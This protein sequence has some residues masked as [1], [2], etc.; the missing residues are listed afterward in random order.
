MKN[1]KIFYLLLFFVLN[2]SNHLIGQVNFKH[3]LFSVL[4]KTLRPVYLNEDSIFI[5]MDGLGG[6]FIIPNAFSSDTLISYLD[7]K[8]SI[9]NILTLRDRD[10]NYYN[11]TYETNV[12]FC[13]DFGINDYVILEIL[14]KKRELKFLIPTHLI[15][16]EVRQSS[17][18]LIEFGKYRLFNFNNQTW[19]LDTKNNLFSIVSYFIKSGK[20]I[21][22]RIRAIT[23]YGLTDI[24]S[25]LNIVKKYPSSHYILN[26]IEESTNLLVDFYQDTISLINLETLDTIRKLSVKGLTSSKAFVDDSLIF[27]FHS[28]YRPIEYYDVL[29][30]YDLN[31]SLIRKDTFDLG[32][33]NQTTEILLKK[34]HFIINAYNY[35][36]PSIFIVPTDKINLIQLPKLK[37]VSLTG[38]IDTLKPYRYGPCSVYELMFNLNLIIK[39]NGNIPINNFI[40]KYS[41]IGPLD[42]FNFDNIRQEGYIIQLPKPLLPGDTTLYNS[43]FYNYVYKP[44]EF[45]NFVNTICFTIPAV[46]NGVNGQEHYEK[47]MERISL[48]S[49]IG[50]NLKLDIYPNPV[51]ERLYLRYASNLIDLKEVKIFDTSGKYYSLVKKETNNGL[52]ILTQGLM[53]GLYFVQVITDI[54]LKTEKFV[55]E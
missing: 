12:S 18:Q 2:N 6:Q 23:E 54:G 39:N 45:N 15:G 17:T 14:N 1:T 30:T 11:F 32:Y 9:S 36:Y 48:T 55:V 37:I 25:S 51:K 46:N 28:E 41:K 42:H 21:N 13:R 24:D 16:S 50:R 43:K 34:H 22:N 10:S 5:R 53:P 3:T 35:T 19:F 33:S 20:V 49:N 7:Y 40:L 26:S 47:C 38:S 29:N 4:G 44:S 8:Q 31:L 27:V 52:E